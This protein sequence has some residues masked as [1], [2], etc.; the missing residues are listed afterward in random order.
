MKMF[1]KILALGM[2]LCL[3]ALCAALGFRI[4]LEDHYPAETTKM[5]MTEELAEKYREAGVLH[6]YTQTLRFSY[7][8][9]KEGNFFAKEL[10]VLPDA[11]HLQITMRYNEST[12]KKVAE[13]YKLPTVPTVAD[14]L[15]Y[16]RLCVSTGD[17][18]YLYYDSSYIAEYSRYFYQYA[19]L[20]FDGVDFTNAVWMR[21]EIYYAGEYEGKMDGED[22]FGMNL[23]YESHVS[24]GEETLE[25]PLYEYDI[26]K[27]V[28]PE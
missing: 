5:V 18:N 17:G 22:C 14:G 16:Y 10:I 25:N 4:Y 12:L 8:D 11:N 1:K 2:T 21:V 20:A 19:K 13:F 28:L 7:D 9:N 23:V 15:F 3:V 26:P 6:A 27:G 24:W